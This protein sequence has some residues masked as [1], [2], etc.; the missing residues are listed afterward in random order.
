MILSVG[1]KGQSI[2]KT[3]FKGL[4]CSLSSIYHL[5]GPGFNPQHCK[6]KKKKGSP[7]IL[8][9]GRVKILWK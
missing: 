1:R 6:M 2:F 4:G 5:S 7:K 3:V 9:E 8:R